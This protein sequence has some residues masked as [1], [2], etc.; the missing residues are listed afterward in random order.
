MPGQSYVSLPAGTDTKTGERWA[1]ALTAR[2]PAG[3]EVLVIA[4]M[5]DG[6]LTIRTAPVHVAIDAVRVASMS[7]AGG[8]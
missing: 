3:K 2:V 8:A 5:I 1:R 4:D 7:A 6:K